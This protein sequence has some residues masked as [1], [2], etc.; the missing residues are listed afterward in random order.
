MRH[1]KNTGHNVNMNRRK[2]RKYVS[3]TREQQAA[4]T[5]SRILDA[6]EHL[7]AQ[8][9]FAGMTV[10]EVAKRAGV[11][12]QTVYAIFSSKA[13]IISAA[14]EDRVLNDDHN[15][16]T[17]KQLLTSDNAMVILRSM[18]RLLCNV[19]QGNAPTFTAVYGARVVSPQLA[20]LDNELGEIRLQKQED[21]VAILMDTGELLP[22]LDAEAVRDIVW[23]L[24][25][26]D[27]Y[28][29][30][31]VQRGWTPERY[32]EQLAAMLAAAI[33]RPEVIAAHQAKAFP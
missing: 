26:R 2:N 23:T 1:I 31:V 19:Y 30:L 21:A 24:T 28:R 18:A 20:E 12:S 14:I 7:L 29:L 15:V 3:P 6:A 13:G 10:A 27:I 4:A 17:I 8:K 25:S 11:S 33:V 32:E 16:D 22:H 5:R 9:G